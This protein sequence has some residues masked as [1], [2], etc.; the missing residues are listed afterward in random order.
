[1]DIII[2]AVIALVIA[3][4]LYTILGERHGGERPRANPFSQNPVKTDPRP[5]AKSGTPK[6]DDEDVL[7][8]P[9][10]PAADRGEANPLAL[11]AVGPAPDSLAGALYSISEADLSFEE[12]SFLKGA[13]VAFEMI[14]HSFAAGER[15]SL[16]NLVAARLYEAFDRAIAAR[17]A[18]GEK[19]DMKMLSLREA[20]ILSARMEGSVAFI[21]VQFISDQNKVTTDRDG[22]SK[23][24]GVEQLTDIWTFRRDTQSRD[25]NWMLAET[26]AI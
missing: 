21:A 5:G 3:Y 8:F 13:R 22:N 23:D 12:K 1:M 15:D 14:V 4:R 19:L 18:A 9:L 25:P 11:G 6:R 17:E 7:A 26:K 24:S 20:Q 10:S 2:Y 16:K